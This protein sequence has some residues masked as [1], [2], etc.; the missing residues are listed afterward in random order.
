MLPK[1]LGLIPRSARRVLDIGVRD[2]SLAEMLKARQSAEVVGLD[3]HPAQQCRR[4]LDQVLAGDPAEV[5]LPVPDH[6]FDVIV[7]ADLLP[8]QREPE[9]LL[10]RAHCWLAPGGR[11]IAGVPNI[12]HHSAVANLLQG[13][14]PHGK[15]GHAAGG[16]LRFFTRRE[17]EKLFY[18]AGFGIPTVN[19]VNNPDLAK[20][21]DQGGPGEVKIDCLHIG[22]LAPEDAEEFYVSEYVVCATP[23]PA[24]DHGL[25]SIVILTHNQLEYTR[26]CLDSI[27]LR[28][29]EPYELIL[30]DNGSTDG[31]VDYLRSLSGVKVI[32]N[33]ANRGFPAGVNQGI[34]IARGRQIL[35]LNNDCIVTTGWL[36]RLLQALKRD[37]R[38][39]LVGP[40]SNYVAGEQQVT[41]QYD[42]D[43]MSLD[44]FAWDW[45]KAHDLVLEDTRKLVGFCLLIRREVID[46]IGLMDEQFGIGNFED[47]DYSLRALEAGYRVVIARDAF[48]HHFGSRTFFGSR[49]DYGAVMRRNQQLF[50]AKWQG[51]LVGR[52]D[53]NGKA[54]VARSGDPATAVPATTGSEGTVPTRS[55]SPALK[56]RAATGGGLLLVRDAVILS[57]CMIARDNGRTLEAA[58]TSI[59]PWVDEMVV[60]DTGSKDK[61]PDIARRLGARVF[62]F[63]W[64]DDFSAARNE[65]VRLARGQWIFWM[66][67]DDTIDETNGPQLRDLVRRPAPPELMGYVMTVRCPLGDDHGSGDFT[68]VHHM[69]VFRNLPELRF[70]G[71]IHEQIIPAI[72]QAGGRWE[73]TDLF[74]VHSGSDHSPEGQAR[75]LERDLRILH[76]EL[77]ERP[78]HPFTLF[79]LGMTYR[80]A[81]QYER[82]EEYL[83][84]SIRRSHP[85]E[86]QLRKTYA[87]LV[88]CCQN[89]KKVDA[90]W[91]ACR[92]GLGLFSEDAELRFLHA[93][94]LH[95]RGRFAEAVDVY[96]GLFNP[97]PERYFSSRNEGIT[98]YLARHNLAVVYTDMDDLASAEEQWRLVVQEKPHYRPGW[99]GLGD[100]LLRQGKLTDALAIA[101]RLRQ[102]RVL[103]PE[104]AVLKSQVL[105]AQGD[106]A[107]ARWLLEQALRKD[108]KDAAL[109][110][111]RCKLLF[112]HGSPGEAEHALRE[113]VRRDPA[114]A[115]AY[116]NLGTVNLREGRLEAAVDC[117]RKSL[118]YRPDSAGTYRHLAT[119]LK[120]CGRIDEAEAAFVEASR[121]EPSPT[122][123]R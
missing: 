33:E 34:Q 112:E 111:A 117:F 115:S 62:H 8:F 46:K 16:R 75:K 44:G 67:S 91:E 51:R 109:E 9:R 99:S 106:V 68:A 11:L 18:R 108:P 90:A 37:Q 81:Q 54:A 121:L 70:D 95:Q 14:W 36:G 4:C 35:L 50:E 103:R 72:N 86:S 5:Q 82:A 22:G 55:E 26:L 97:S 105:A 52:P 27:R 73:W 118:H 45:G 101:E 12:R 85:R 6:Y 23:A 102:D 79:N 107:G 120:E 87:F 64:C 49:V 66:D 114:D 13:T 20:W 63:P 29:D 3:T 71:R 84:R 28:T 39:G 88:D 76:Q 21:R 47:D 2:G 94:L 93:G 100:S 40:C 96:R 19:P 42:D 98:G 25:T 92:E 10:C 59:K 123:G 1:L 113:R 57:M 65:S 61:T 89:L 116:H 78:D 31:T 122:G 74:I 7:C 17:I 60:V 104:G 110:D 24:V 32:L 56:V 69:K 48:V 77:S 119:A 58:L 30:V 41:V 53:D 15:N 80:D 38:I 83:R 43:L